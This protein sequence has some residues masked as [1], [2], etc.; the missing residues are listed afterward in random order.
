MSE[1]PTQKP[2]IQSLTLQSA[3]AIAIAAAADRLGVALPEGA[4][5]ELAGRLHRPCRHAWPDRR[6]RRP[7]A[8]AHADRLRSIDH[9][10]DPLRVLALALAL[11][12]TPACASLPARRNPDR[13]PRRR[14]AHA[15][16][17]RLCAAARLRRRRRRGDR[18]RPRSGRAARASSARSARPNA[19]PRRRPKR[20]RSRCAPTCAHARIS[21][22]RPA[23][24]SRRFERAATA[25]TI[26]AQRLSEAIAA[27]E[28]PIAELEDLVRARRG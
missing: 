5:Q 18:H 9:A 1:T 20:S 7:R 11:A 27:A 3:A 23:K 8:C 2:A 6:R 26:A 28:A 17:A 4:A 10:S 13:E 16:P 14:R 25:L 24:P 15:R 19:S 22:R 12:A 21:K